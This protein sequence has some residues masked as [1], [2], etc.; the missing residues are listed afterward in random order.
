MTSLWSYNSLS[1]IA[2]Q[3]QAL[4]PLL[5]SRKS[6]LYWD[7]NALPQ[8]LEFGICASDVMG[9]C[10]PLVDIAPIADRLILLLSED[11][12]KN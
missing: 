4:L 12:V 5:S 7:A 1:G 6:A 2:G 11:D 3:R 9:N 8:A 10:Q